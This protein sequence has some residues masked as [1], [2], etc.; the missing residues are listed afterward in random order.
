MKMLPVVL[1]ILLVISASGF[2]NYP[3]DEYN[4]AL[5]MQTQLEKTPIEPAD[6]E[7]I[8]RRYNFLTGELPEISPPPEWQTGMQREFWVINTDKPAT[9]AVTAEAVFIGEHFVAW[10]Q[11]GSYNSISSEIIYQFTQFDQDIYPELRS[12][13]GEEQSPGIDH[14]MRIHALFTSEAGSGIL[15]YFSSRDEDHPSVSPHSNA[16]EMFILDAAMLNGDPRQVTNTLAHE[17]QHMIHFAHDPNEDSNIDEGFSGYAELL[18]GNRLSTTYEKSFLSNPDVSISH[19]PVDESGIPSY[20]ASFL[21]T[22]YLADRL[23]VDFL[24]LIVQEPENGLDG[25]DAALNDTYTK[26]TSLSANRFYAEWIAA[27][28]LNALGQSQGNYHYNDYE[29]PIPGNQSMIQ[30]LSCEGQTVEST[31]RQYGTDYYQL[32][33]N[34]GTY[35]IE[36]TGEE[37]IPVLSLSSDD[38]NISWW[39]NSGSNSNTWMQRNF[40]LTQTNAPVSLQFR[41]N[42]DLENAFDFLYLLISTDDGESWQI[43][44]SKYG[45]DDNESGFNLG[46]GWTG[47]SN[48]WKDESIDLSSYAGK[49]VIIRFD[50][51]TDQALS[52]Q[53][54]LIDDIRIDP[55]NFLDEGQ[56]LYPEWTASGFVRLD[57]LLPQ[58]YTIV[59]VTGQTV[60][61]SAAIETSN[62]KQLTCDFNETSESIC[63]FGISPINRLSRVPAPYR[64][65]IIKTDQ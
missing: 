20:G 62:A 45:T 43:L 21:F 2:S 23:G 17:F 30:P 48:G 31:A 22:K 40:D 24:K 12:V 63:A 7:T 64:I 53:G 49:N 5:T 8:A 37:T 52:A 14:D 25:I 11:T 57:N 47:K 65:K 27:N 19:W 46:L 42:Y 26:D 41:L 33:C 1:F 10:V 18:I 61:E 36:I 59:S 3:S 6:R 28:L 34:E 15:G 9:I 60:A 51:I 58:N 35:Q 29:L 44:K 50:M 56:P 38:E 16:M 13:F 4:R 55:I 32:D 54:A 39:S